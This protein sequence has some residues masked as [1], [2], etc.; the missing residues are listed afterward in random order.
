MDDPGPQGSSN[1]YLPGR[2]R[3]AWT[4]HDHAK[5]CEHMDKVYAFAE[6]LV[7]CITMATSAWQ[8]NKLQLAAY[9]PLID[10]AYI[11]S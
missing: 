1:M 9:S 4:F 7:K 8:E 10:V 6:V 11:T 3:H 2:V 5:F